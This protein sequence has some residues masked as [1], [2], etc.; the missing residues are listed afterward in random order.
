M[1]LNCGP[2]ENF[3]SLLDSKEIKPV[4]P[5]GNHTW[6]VFGRGNA[7]ADADV[8][9]LWPPDTKSHLI[10][11][12]PAAGKDWGQTQKGTTEDKM[13][14][15]S[16]GWILWWLDGIT[17]SMDMSLSKLREIVKD[18]EPWHTSVHGVAKSW[19]LLSDWTTRTYTIK[20]ST[21]AIES[22]TAIQTSQS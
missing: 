20:N 10:R 6:I 22:I 8:P 16:D 15:S 11:K 1:I 3:W 18:R 7:D 19:T 17:N 12:G 13:V 4:Y 9:I 5:K 21:S 14:G 2:G